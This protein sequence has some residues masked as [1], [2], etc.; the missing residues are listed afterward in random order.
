LVP[1]RLLLLLLLLLTLP[2][3]AGRGPLV[4]ASLRAAKEARRKLKVYA[5]E[6][7]PAAVVH[8]QVWSGFSLGSGQ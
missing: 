4:R 2:W 6:K 7:N 8:I 3:P 1:L 5:V